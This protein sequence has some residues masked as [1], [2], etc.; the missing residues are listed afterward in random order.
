MKCIS[1][2]ARMKKKIG[3]YRYDES[4]L[5]DVTLAGVPIYTCRCGEI[6]PLIRNTDELHRV[7]AYMLTK[8]TAPLTGPE[9]RFLRKEMGMNAKE[10][11]KLLG[12][13]PITVSR[14]ETGNKNI[15]NSNDRLIRLIYIRHLEGLC[16]KFIDT[17]MK[18]VLYNITPEHSGKVTIPVDRLPDLLPCTV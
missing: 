16:S 10:I 1:C 6:S 17:D 4:G 5:K 18:T 7:I 3:N 2:G 14:W 12:V 11:A 15:G 8:K 9:F 13:S